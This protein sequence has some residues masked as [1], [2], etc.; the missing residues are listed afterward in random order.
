MHTL[1]RPCVCS[2]AHRNSLR[3]TQDLFSDSC[4][5]FC[6]II[7]LPL[8]IKTHSHTLTARQAS[9]LTP[10]TRSAWW[11]CTPQWAACQQS[12]CPHAAHSS[13]SLIKWKRENLILKSVCIQ[14]SA[15]P[16]TS[17]HWCK[18]QHTSATSPLFCLYEA[19]MWHSHHVWWKVMMGIWFP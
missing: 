17:Y 9:L 4:Y 1:C 13:R 11:L 5:Q 2:C 16:T 15:A 14:H 18:A 12:A 8:I 3:H 6:M 19:V 10:A 7:T